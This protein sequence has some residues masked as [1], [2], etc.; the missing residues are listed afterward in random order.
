VTTTGLK[1]HTRQTKVRQTFPNP[2][3]VAAILLAAGQSRRMGAFKPLLPFGDTTV[4][5]ACLNYLTEGGAGPL[6]VVVGHR[7]NDIRQQLGDYPVTFAVNPDPTSEMAAS[8]T[9]GVRQLP[10]TTRAVLIALAD[11]PAVPSRVISLLI[12]EWSMGHRLVKPTWKGRGGHPVLLDLSLRDDLLNLPEQ[13]GLKEVFERYKDEVLRVE[14]G[15]PYV[16][17]DLDT[18]D[19]YQRLH[20]EIF[21]ESPP[22]ANSNEK[23]DGLI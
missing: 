9:A 14:V 19:D 11:Y 13:N 2:S 10:E 4:I 21:G 8:I 3:S 23:L 5:E 15:T 17:R 20:S 6:V 18:W 16:A 7:A 1:L 22:E 12:K